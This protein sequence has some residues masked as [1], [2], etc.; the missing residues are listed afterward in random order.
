M[1]LDFHA[2][3]GDEAL[4]FF[5]E[6][7]GEGEGGDALDDGG[8]DDDADDPGQQVEL[9]LAH[10]VVDEVF[11]GSGQDQAA[12]AVDDHQQEAAAEQHAA[13]L[14]ELPDLRED[15]FE[16]GLGA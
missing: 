10:D 8:R 15:L 9:V 4:A 7:L 3:F 11:G 14:D 16:L 6:K 13:G 2:E 12:E 1:G 5:G